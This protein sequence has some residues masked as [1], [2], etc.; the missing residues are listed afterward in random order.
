ME[1]LDQGRPLPV[2]ISIL[3]TRP[4]KL[5][6]GRNS[7]VGGPN[8]ATKP[9]GGEPALRHD[10]AAITGKHH[11]PR[12]HQSRRNDLR[13]RRKGGCAETVIGATVM[14]SMLAIDRSAAE[15]RLIAKTS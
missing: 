2:V 9:S 6:P 1:A 3:E 5:V 12:V 4:V 10:Q 14:A 11:P 7:G 13:I 15:I 8:G